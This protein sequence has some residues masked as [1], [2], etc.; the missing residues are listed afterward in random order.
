MLLLPFS[1][2]DYVLLDYGS[3]LNFATIAAN[4]GHDGNVDPTP[5]LMPT[6]IESLTDFSH[7][8]VHVSA[9]LG[10]QITSTYYGASPHHSYYDGCSAGGRQ[11]ISVAS[12]YPEDFDGILVGAPAVN[13]NRFVGALGIWASFVAANTSSA[14]PLPLWGTVITPEILK[15]CD[16]LDG[17]VDGIITDPTLCSWNPD[18]LLC[19]PEDDG[20]TCLTRDQADGLRKLYHPILGTNGD[21]IFPAYDSG[22]ENNTVVPFPMNG[23]IPT[24]TTVR[25]PLLDQLDRVA[26]YSLAVAFNRRSGTTT[27]YTE[28]PCGR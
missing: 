7:R 15:Q 13:W 21:V 11:G 26:P 8:A 10:K 1:G 3:S 2:V 28:S 22:A 19:G 27:R 20:T 23:A 5:F 17:R 12:R 16:G 25:R 24:F 14:I 18:T 9:V 4:G 6:R